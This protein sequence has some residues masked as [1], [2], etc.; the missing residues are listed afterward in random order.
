[1]DLH[2]W[3]QERNIVG[4]HT[5]SYGRRWDGGVLQSETQEDIYCSCHYYFVP[6]AHLFGGVCSM[7]SA[8]SLFLSHLSLCSDPLTCTNLFGLA[9]H[10]PL[11]INSL[12]VSDKLYCW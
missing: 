8:I 2:P 5:Y 12:D 6:D 4:D 11:L 7:K 9:L 10:C 1:M 3:S